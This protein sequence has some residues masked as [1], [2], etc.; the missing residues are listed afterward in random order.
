MGVNVPRDFMDAACQFL[1]CR[2]GCV[3]F[4]YLGLPVGANSKKVSTWETYVGQVKE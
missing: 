3:P 4:N 1:H 2:E